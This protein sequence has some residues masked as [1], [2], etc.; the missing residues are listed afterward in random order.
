MDWVICDIQALRYWLGP[1]KVTRTY[2]PGALCSHVSDMGASS[3]LP[4]DA[5]RRLGFTE[6]PAHLLVPSP[7]SHRYSSRVVTHAWKPPYP[8]GTFVRL[9]PNIYVL[10]PI[11][12]L[13]RMAPSLGPV[14]T[15]QYAYRLV[16]TYRIDGEGIHQRPALATKDAMGRYVG[17]AA[18]M[19]GAKQLR[20]AARYLVENA[21]SP[22]EAD[23]AIMLVLPRRLGGYGLPLPVL[24]K[25]ISIP[26]DGGVEERRPDIM[27]EK[28]DIIAEYLGERYHNR[29][30]RFGRDAAR[31]THLQAA[32]YTVVDV[33][34]S[35]TSS[36]A[37]L[38]A[39]AS[40]IRAHLGLPE[41][42]Q[43]A[44]YSKRCEKLRAELFDSKTM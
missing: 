22:K 21:A 41:P 5:L 13:M 40:V 14:K 4:V 34:K 32:G 42:E 12:S 17:A 10:S 1:Q 29:D 7:E 18:G 8:P 26:V 25:T 44:E 6:T 24:N 19:R 27:W 39:V 33:T 31:K 30:D 3:K 20:Q 9:E 2:A 43:D 37:E 36:K 28:G 38:D 11:A 35:Q 15:L 23:L 16:G